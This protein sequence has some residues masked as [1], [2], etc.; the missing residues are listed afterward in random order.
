MSVCL[1]PEAESSTNAVASPEN[2][3]SVWP[4]KLD[5]FG[6]GVTPTTYA[7]ATNLVIE[8]GR[9]GEQKLVSCYAVHS[10]ISFC[11]E[12]HLRDVSNDFDLITPDGQ[13]V[14]WALNLLHGTGLEDRVYGPGLMLHICRQAAEQGVSIYLFGGSSEVAETLHQNLKEMLPGLKIAGYESPPFRALTPEE[15]QAV[16][17]RIN[18]SGA[19]IVFIGLGCPKQDLFAHEHRHS[20]KAVQVCVGAAFDFHAGMKSTAPAWL[21]KRGLE[22]AFRL[23]QEPKRLWHRYLVTNTSFV[24]RLICSLMNVPMVI[25]QRVKQAKR[26]VAKH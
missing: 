16:I 4:E 10:L 5:I 26:H 22:W 13:P 9:Q 17:D 11:S 24:V 1:N 8:A 25:R 15:N 23:S 19:G 12:P 2:S 6:V 18:N 7:E 14:R 3:T 21:Q 20:I